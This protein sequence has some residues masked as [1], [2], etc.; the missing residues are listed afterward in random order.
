MGDGFDEE[1][2]GKINLPS[3]PENMTL[4]KG[5]FNETLPSFVATN[6]NKKISYLHIDCDL[7]SSA[8]QVGLF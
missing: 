5:W 3:V 1:C 7:Y 4:V 6:T 2:F 8:N